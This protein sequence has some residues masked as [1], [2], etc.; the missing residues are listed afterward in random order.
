GFFEGRVN[1]W[2]KEG[3]RNDSEIVAT[4]S[5]LA[6][7]DAYTKGGLQPTT[8]VALDH[9]LRVQQQDGSW[10][11]K[12]GQWPPLQH[13]D[14]YGATIAALGLGAAPAEYRKSPEA[15]VAIEKLRQYFKDNRSPNLHHSL[16]LLWAAG[17][18]PELMAQPERTALIGKVMSLQKPDGGW[19]LASL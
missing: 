16:M 7:T 14:Y 11:W 12:R 10:A 4:A 13:D 1:I 17:Y 3:A 5:F 8:R 19:S 18:F 9:M 6:L 15:R 2:A